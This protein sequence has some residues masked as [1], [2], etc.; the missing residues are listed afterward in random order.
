MWPGCIYAA[1]RDVR[2]SKSALP[3]EPV[4]PGAHSGDTL[5]DAAR[6]RG[7][8]QGSKQ[9]PQPLCC[10]RLDGTVP[11]NSLLNLRVAVA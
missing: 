1:V 6:Q 9:R 7:S 4:F 8:C 3:L 10:P 2:V 11:G 5:T